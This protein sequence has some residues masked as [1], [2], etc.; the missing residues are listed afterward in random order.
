MRSLSPPSDPLE[1]L[2]YDIDLVLA[3]SIFVPARASVKIVSLESGEVL[4]ERESKMLMRPASNMKLL[5]SSSALQIL[6]KDFL[7]K[8][9]VHV[10]SI[11]MDGVLYGN[12]YL[13][14]FGDP[15]L[16]TAHLDTLAGQI[17]LAGINTITGDVVG[18]ASYFDDEYW[19]AG[20][21]WDDEPF[22]DEMFITALSVNNN[23]VRI[24]VEPGL[25]AGDSTRVTID[26]ITNHVLLVN[27]AKTVTDTVL[28]PLKITR[29]FKERSNIIIVDGEI[30]AGSSPSEE[31]LSVWKPELYA[32]ELFKEALE[33][34]GILVKGR[35]ALGTLPPYARAAASHAQSMDSM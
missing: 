33:R 16:K 20:W 1:R 25:Y 35:P 11:M 24:K 18:D 8:T 15:D 30:L 6:G 19:G 34:A 9:S 10:D 28:Q 26:P 4:Y 7:F 3:D 17:K 14:G 32:T 31:E 5:T 12:I 21:M 23:C 22:S 27:F 13:K 29:L 2:K